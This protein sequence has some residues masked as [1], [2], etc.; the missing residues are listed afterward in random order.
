VKQKEILAMAAELRKL[1]AMQ[2]KCRFFEV[3]I[4]QPAP[5]TRREKPRRKMGFK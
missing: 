1:G 4:Y 5:K 2:F 3:V